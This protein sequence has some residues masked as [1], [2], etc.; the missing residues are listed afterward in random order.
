MSGA[1]AYYQKAE[2]L[3]PRCFRPAG[4]RPALRSVG[5]G[6]G[7]ASQR[8]IGFTGA[9]EVPFDRAHP[10]LR[11][12][13]AVLRYGARLRQAADR[14]AGF[15]DGRAGAARAEPVARAVRARGDGHRDSRALPIGR[16]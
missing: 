3:T 12:R 2:W 4:H 8:A 16:A 11:R 13:T 15:G 9:S 5:V 14:T 10:A 7:L 1:G 6:A